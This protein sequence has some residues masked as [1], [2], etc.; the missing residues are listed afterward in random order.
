[1]FLLDLTCLCQRKAF[2]ARGSG[3]EDGEPSFARRQTQR[4]VHCFC[5]AHIDC[6]IFTYL[7]DRLRYGFPIVCGQNQIK[8]R[9]ANGF[10][11]GYLYRIQDW[12]CLRTI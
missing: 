3:L 4:C 12:S 5:W 9:M 6:N 8:Q 7:W 1:M 11:M 2:G 10:V